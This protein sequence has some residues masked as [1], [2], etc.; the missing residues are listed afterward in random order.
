MFNH[1]L[2]GQENIMIL[3]PFM[4]AKATSYISGQG[5]MTLTQPAFH[6][7]VPFLHLMTEFGVGVQ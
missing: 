7:E 2:V 5:E 1:L 6:R 4:K 3:Q